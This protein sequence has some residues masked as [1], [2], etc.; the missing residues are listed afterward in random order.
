MLYW[1]RAA[2]QLVANSHAQSQSHP[3]SHAQQ[4]M[5]GGGR[6]WQLEQGSNRF[7]PGTQV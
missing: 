6:V 5:E 7:K 3:L 1:V 4:K 2:N